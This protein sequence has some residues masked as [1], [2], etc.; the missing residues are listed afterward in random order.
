MNSVAKTT[1]CCT[2]CSNVHHWHSQQPR[3]KVGFSLWDQIFPLFFWASFLKD[4]MK[5]LTPNTFRVQRK[6]R[7]KFPAFHNISTTYFFKNDVDTI[8]DS[9]GWFTWHDFCL[10]L[11]H[12]TSV[13]C[14]AHAMQK[15]VY[16]TCHSILPTPMTVVWF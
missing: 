11:S 6:K 4:V 13:A 3:Y 16:D 15:I 9:E 7:K 10:L 14:A 8:W 12:A 2:D 1:M 5:I